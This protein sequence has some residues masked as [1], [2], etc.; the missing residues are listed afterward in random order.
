M[1]ASQ[2][3]LEDSLFED[4]SFEEKTLRFA[5]DAGCMVVYITRERF[6]DVDED[7]EMA[8]LST[9]VAIQINE[10]AEIR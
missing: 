9:F 1:T 3:E 2:Q 4:P 7:G 8:F 6:Y 10:H 5:T